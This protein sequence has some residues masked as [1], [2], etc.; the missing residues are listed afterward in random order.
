MIGR[1]LRIGVFPT[2][3]TR[4]RVLEL[5]RLESPQMARVLKAAGI[6]PE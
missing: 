6:Q 1:T 4:E 3:T 5:I 2:Y